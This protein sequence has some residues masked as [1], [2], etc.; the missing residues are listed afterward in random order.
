MDLGRLFTLH[1]NLLLVNCGKLHGAVWMGDPR[2]RHFLRR[3][4]RRH[5]LR[6]LACLEV[7]EL[8]LAILD[9]CVPAYNVLLEAERVLLGLDWENM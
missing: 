4:L 3:S 9:P 6:C 2:M 5:Q 8:L 1:G 7:C